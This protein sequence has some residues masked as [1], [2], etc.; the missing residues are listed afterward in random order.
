MING[1]E[2]G[3]IRNAQASV[4]NLRWST[5]HRVPALMQIGADPATG[6]QLEW[7][8]GWGDMPLQFHLWDGDGDDD[9]AADVRRQQ[10]ERIC[11]R[12]MVVMTENR[13]HGRKE[14]NSWEFQAS[15]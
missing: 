9:V 12:I 10:A 13:P 1:N 14:R 2:A 4:Q 15:L 5:D 7:S 3:I 11:Q 6:M 8:G